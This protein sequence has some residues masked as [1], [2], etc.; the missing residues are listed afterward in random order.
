MTASTSTTTATFAVPPPV[1]AIALLISS[2]TITKAQ[3]G[4]D[5]PTAAAAVSRRRPTLYLSLGLAP[6]LL[7]SS[8]PHFALSTSSNYW[9]N[10]DISSQGCRGTVWSTPLPPST[11]EC[12]TFPFASWS[13][14]RN[15]CILW[16]WRRRWTVRPCLFEKGRFSH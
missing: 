11:A 6:L 8:L 10:D 14:A 12:C 2:I 1:V 13:W 4:A 9:L 5:S 7:W 16:W 3:R 15:S